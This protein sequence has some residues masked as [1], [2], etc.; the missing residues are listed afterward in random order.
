MVPGMLSTGVAQAE[1]DSVGETS[2]GPV[3]TP[4]FSQ[5][6]THSCS[7]IG[8][9]VSLS[10]IRVAGKLETL[11]YLFSALCVLRNMVLQRGSTQI[12]PQLPLLPLPGHSLVVPKTNKDISDHFFETVLLNLQCV[13]VWVDGWV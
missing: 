12:P 7:H 3:A 4:P 5:P 10:W 6:T 8:S 1:V 13:Y 11:T 9:A 2:T